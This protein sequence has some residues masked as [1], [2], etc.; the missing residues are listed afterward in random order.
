MPIA[1]IATMFIF[2]LPYWIQSG[3]DVIGFLPE[4]V[5]ER[6]NLSP[7]L[8]WLL[9]NLPGWLN[10][11]PSSQYSD[12][13]RILSS[14]GLIVLALVSLIMI[15]KPANSGEQAVRRSIWPIGIFILFNLNLFSWYLL[16]LLP[17]VAIFMEFQ[18]IRL[19]RM[20]THSDSRNRRY[21][22]M[23]LPRFD[24]WTGWWLF[25][26]LVVLSYTFFIRWESITLAIHLQYWPLYIFLLIDLLRCLRH[27]YLK[28]PTSGEAYP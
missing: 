2:Y 3:V 11:N 13:H 12:A 21:L 4:Y 22:T 24:A 15:L 17:L 28:Q 1:L 16:W 5:G 18:T 8:Y 23:K 9:H 25:T 20:F 26:G 14:F 27:R 7:L 6:F 10:L 19:P